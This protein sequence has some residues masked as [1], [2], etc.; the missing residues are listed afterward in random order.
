MV[1]AI[2]AVNTNGFGAMCSPPG[3]QIWRIFMGDK[4]G[5]S[6][7]Y[8]TLRIIIILIETI[9]DLYIGVGQVPRHDFLN[10]FNGRVTRDTIV[11]LGR[12]SR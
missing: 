3:S 1:N 5:G 9:K 8:F 6:V 2:P 7:S 4:R 11:T 10:D 12:G